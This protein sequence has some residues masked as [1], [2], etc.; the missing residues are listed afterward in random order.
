MTISD[1]SDLQSQI[2]TLFPDN[3]AGNISAQDLRTHLLDALDSQIIQRQLNIFTSAANV[4]ITPDQVDQNLTHIFTP[5]P[6][7]DQTMT[8]PAITS[9]LIGRSM[10]IF[11]DYTDQQL[12]LLGTG[13]DTIVGRPVIA[14]NKTFLFVKCLDAT[15]WMVESTVLGSVG[16]ETVM[17]AES[18]DTQTPSGLDTP[19]QIEF[20]PAQSN[21]VMSISAAGV[22]TMHQVGVY[23][24]RTT[25]N[26]SRTT[27]AGEAFFFVRLLRDGVQLGNAIAIQQSD[28]N[29][30]IPIFINEIIP[31]EV[32]DLGVPFTLE[33]IRD[34]QGIDN[35]SLEGL[36]STNGWGETPSARIAISRF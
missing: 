12:T 3:I 27:S 4:N 20:G 29:I 8:L 35:G 24:T 23:Q 26:F 17:R 30:T 13:G 33:C 34:G 6:A 32:A 11:L 15:R 25:L 28:D 22:I 5:A 1:K 19:L 18:T 9:D 16:P 21:N 2:A 31:I 10:S 7:V 14:A 36:T